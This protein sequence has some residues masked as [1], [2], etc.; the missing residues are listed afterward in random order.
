MAEN[1]LEVYR[2]RSAEEATPEIIQMCLT[3]KPKVE[4]IIDT[5][6]EKFIAVRYTSEVFDEGIRF[7]VQVDIGDGEV[8][9]ICILKP[10]DPELNPSV[11]AVQ[12][13][14]SV[15]SL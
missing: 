13:S 4:A 7:F 15:E 11:V 6:F 8:L 10:D 1:D 5:K 9:H 2:T 14:R 3:L 12:V